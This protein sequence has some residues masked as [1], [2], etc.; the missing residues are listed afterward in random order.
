MNIK[1]YPINESLARRA[2][3]MRSFS[4]YVPNTATNGYIRMLQEFSDAVDRLLDRHG[5]TAEQL[6]AVSY[7]ADR[8]SQ[9]LAALIDKENHVNTMCP[10]VMIT[11]SG[12][13]PVR[14][15]QKQNEAWDRLMREQGELYTPTNNYYFR[16]IETLLTNKTIYSND[17]LAVEK[18]QNKLS[19]HEELHAKMKAQNAYYRKHGTMKGYEGITDEE[20]AERDAKIKASMYWEQQPFPSYYL[21]SNNAEIKRIKARIESITKLKAEAEKPTEDRYPQI[22]GVKVVENAEA[23]RIQ[24]IFDGKPSEDVRAVLKSHGFRWSPSFGAWQRQL[25]ENGK[26]ATR[27]ALE[28]IAALNG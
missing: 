7:Y 10:S 8:Y 19:D 16:K 21:S 9:K 2:K 14:K 27:K 3:E 24:L 18:L 26:Y 20:A 6:E 11:G 1:Q 15:K 25:T 12:N 5:A 4:D 22:D 23:M 17:E 13:F 28:E